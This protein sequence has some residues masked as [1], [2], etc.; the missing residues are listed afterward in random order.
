MQQELMR[1][2]CTRMRHFLFMSSRQ[3]CMAMQH[4]RVVFT[5]SCK[6]V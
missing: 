2:I 3:S 1:I 4:I 6:Y 5:A